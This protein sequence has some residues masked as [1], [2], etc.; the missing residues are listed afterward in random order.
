MLCGGLRGS[1]QFLI[2]EKI[3]VLFRLEQRMGGKVIFDGKSKNGYQAILLVNM[4][5]L[6]W[7]NTK[8]FHFIYFIPLGVCQMSSQ[9]VDAVVY[10]SEAPVVML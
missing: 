10:M 3:Y 7:N 9:V 6:M 5:I 8:K 1:V 4:W 2:F